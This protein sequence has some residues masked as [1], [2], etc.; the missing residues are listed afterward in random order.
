MV[1]ALCG[2][3][4]IILICHT[5]LVKG[6][7]M[8]TWKQLGLQDSASSIIEEFTF[9]HDYIIVTLV[10]I[11]TNV[12]IVICFLGANR[13]L[14][15]VRSENQI[16]ETIWTLVPALILINLAIPSLTLLYMLEEDVEHP[17]LVKAIG[18]Q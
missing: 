18:H 1:L 9:F 11:I 16:L 12:L 10:L 17:L 13:T 8:R 3:G 7:L 15:L 14:R 4:V 5:L 6:K 2:C